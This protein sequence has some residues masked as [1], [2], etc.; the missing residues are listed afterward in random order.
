M[1]VCGEEK[2]KAGGRNRGWGYRRRK[3]K[4]RNGGDGGEKRARGEIAASNLNVTL[5]KLETK[6]NSCA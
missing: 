1:G 3:R 6:L 4:R 5:S 2:W